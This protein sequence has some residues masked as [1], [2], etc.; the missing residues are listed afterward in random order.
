MSEQPLSQKM[1]V[2]YAF[3][4]YIAWGL[5]PVYWKAIQTV[6]AL[7]ILSHRILWSFV[8]VAILLVVRKQWGKA[9]D[10]LR[11]PSK[12]WGLVLS[13][14][15]VTSNWFIYIWAV[16][17]NQVVEAS[18]GYYI[19]PLLTVLLGI[20]VLHERMDRW[21]I[22]SLVLA[23]LGVMI[24][25]LEYGKIPWIS[26]GLAMT[27]ALYGLAKRLVEVDSLLGLALETAVVVPI[28]LIYLSTVQIRGEG[29]VGHTGLFTLLLL[30]GA[31]IV[32][33]LPLLSFAQAAKTI[34]FATI[35][36][37]QY[38]SP[39]LSLVLGVFLYHEEFTSAHAFSFGTIWIALAIYSVSRMAVARK[40]S[41]RAVS[42]LHG[43]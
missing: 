13:A 11:D 39:S 17:N 5:L 8:L 15:L 3:F 19:N 6:P 37:I 33:A 26:L 35:G 21:Q 10:V 20:V 43:K 18:L 31:G 22:V 14:L 34:P 32:T 27:F 36:F 30:I 24:L 12:M 28:A 23:A 38:V 41:L 2:F 25:T 16:N 40:Q 29:A 9:R 42:S 7:Q 1:G 4:A